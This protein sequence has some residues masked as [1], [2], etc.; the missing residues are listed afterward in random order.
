MKRF[1]LA[2]LLAL[3]LPAAACRK[4]SAP[5][6]APSAPAVQAAPPTPKVLEHEPNDV[7]HAQLIPARAIVLGELTPKKG[8]NGP[9]DDDWYRIEPGPN[10]LYALRVELAAASSVPSATGEPALGPLDAQLE[11]S[12]RDRNRLLLVHATETEPAL[13]PAVAC[14]AACYVHIWGS[15]S[16]AYQ[17]TVLG[18]VPAENQEL[19]PNDR[20]VDATPL[21]AGKS[22]QGTLASPDDQD[23]YKLTAQPR[24]GQFLR[25]ELSGVPGVRPEI[26]LRALADGALLASVRAPEEGEG[27]FLR[28]LSLA[29][30]SAPP[31]PPQLR[32]AAL[33]AG[34]SDSDAA[35]PAGADGGTDART[36]AGPAPID[37]TQNI[38][39]ATN[40][41]ADAGAL[42]EG[43]EG[44][45]PGL[46]SQP[47]RL[48][49][50]LDVGQPLAANASSSALDAGANA[51]LAAP[52]VQGYYLVVR[53]APLTHEKKA[54]R[55]A[56][57]NVAY[58]L[59]TALEAGAAD[60]EAEPNDDAAHA[61][62]LSSTRTGYLAPAGDADWYRVRNEGKSVLRAEV[63]GLSRADLELFVYAPPQHPGEKPQLLA[64]AN[65]G[66]VR[67]GELLPAVGIDGDALVLVQCAP[68]ELQGQKV[69]DCEDRDSP[70]TLSIALAADDGALEREPNDDLDHAQPLALPA[71]VIGTLWPKRD[72]DLFRFDLDAPRTLSFRLSAIRGV[73]AMLTLRELKSGK[74]GHLTSE[75]IGTADASHGEGAEEILAVPLKPGSY[76]IEVSSPRRDGSATQTYTLSVQ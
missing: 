61:T 62:W 35:A 34:G 57:A 67:E 33:D 55:G 54:R 49:A 43:A 30:E 7:L 59:A 19:E 12:D 28:D 8:A 60:L 76:A 46:P 24:P 70:Y 1:E 52:A 73:D 17:L 21:A 72:T 44:S 16:A 63:T 31:E 64:H 41:A 36:D 45:A 13:I 15:A 20:A 23:W 11:V 51:S 40:S 6:Q 9:V 2:L 47:A 48:A 29:G 53:S 50:A 37:G 42:A 38:G 18:D 65:E 66:G 69:R 26:E 3:A 39:T 74:G 5:V 22:V 32:K 75:V 10:T 25:V 14:F 56:N 71:R 58:S 27:I 68:R 4:A